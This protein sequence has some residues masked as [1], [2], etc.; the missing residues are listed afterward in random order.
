[1]NLPLPPKT[2]PPPPTAARDRVTVSILGVI[3][4]EGTGKGVA[5]AARLGMAGLFL[6]AVKVVLPLL[7]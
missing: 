5:L 3:K 1:M 7:H 4:I 6:V 2:P